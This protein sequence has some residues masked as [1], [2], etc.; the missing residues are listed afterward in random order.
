[1]HNFFERNS[2]VHLQK[3]DNRSC[4]I[5]MMTLRNYNHTFWRRERERECEE[6]LEKKK[7]VRTNARTERNYG[8]VEADTVGNI[9]G[10]E[11][12]G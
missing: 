3:K 1:M 4:K 9:E 10:E 7:K 8:E 11:F 6:L 5:E 2:A 12:D